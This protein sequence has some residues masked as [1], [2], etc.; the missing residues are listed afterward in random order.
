MLYVSGIII[1]V[2]KTGIDSVASL[3]STLT[4]GLSI[5]EPINISIGAVAA[6]G[7]IKNRGDKNR[8]KRNITATVNDV[9]PVRPPSATPEALSK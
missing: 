5:N 9:K 7:T 6:A 1:T 4:I 3:K 2:K 8:A